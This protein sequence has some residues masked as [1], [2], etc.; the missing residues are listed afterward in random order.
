ME[1]MEKSGGFKQPNLYTN[2]MA[3]PTTRLTSIYTAGVDD[4]AMSAVASSGISP[5]QAR[6]KYAERLNQYGLLKDS[7][8]AAAANASLYTT[9]LPSPTSGIRSR[10][11]LHSLGGEKPLL[12]S[13]GSVSST[14]GDLY[15]QQGYLKP[16]T[17]NL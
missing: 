8:A 16:L 17:G 13:N 4:R 10:P 11:P 14:T 5:I 7:T 2:E 6:D 9:T 15:N 1:Y 3:P 12:T